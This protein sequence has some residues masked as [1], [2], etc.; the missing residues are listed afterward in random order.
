[1][2]IEPQFY[3]CSEQHKKKDNN[4]KC[5]LSWKYIAK[6]RGGDLKIRCQRD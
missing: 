6:G 2:G 3:A 4:R 1:L 5:Q